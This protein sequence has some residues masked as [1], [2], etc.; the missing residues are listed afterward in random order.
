M[1]EINCILIDDEAAGRIVLTELLAKFCPDVNIVGEAANITEAYNLIKEKKPDFVFLDIQMPGGSGFELL[2]QFD[3]IEF[4]VIFVT[5]YD[6]YA[7][8]AIKFSALDYLLKPVEI[9]GLID[10]VEKVRKRKIEKER[11]NEWIITLIDNLDEKNKNKKIAIHHQDRVKFLQLTDIVCLEAE[12][13][14]THIFTNDGQRYTPA[15][16]LKDFEEFLENHQSFIRVNK[17]A[18]V[19]LDYVTEYSKSEPHILFMKNGKEYE[20]GR[21]KRTEIAGRMR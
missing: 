12:S 19:N 5:S 1:T 2:K 21:R 3:K 8:N 4:D 15:R 14:Y 6:Q 10:S 9:E 13:N 7:I 20:I 11:A 18:I 17:K 16:V